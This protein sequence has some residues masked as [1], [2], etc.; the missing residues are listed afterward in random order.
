MKILIVTAEFGLNGGGLSLSCHK[1][2]ELLSS[3]DEVNVLNSTIRPIET[4]IGSKLHGVDD[5]IS[6]EY[7]LKTDSNDYQSTDIVIGFG[8]KFNGYYASLLAKKLKARFILSLRGSDVNLAKWSCENSWFLQEAVSTAETIV[9]LSKEMR[10][11]ILLHNH[12]AGP[13]TIIIPNIITKPISE[14]IR[15]VN[16]P[17]SVVIG[18]A[19]THLNEKKGITNL[20]SMIYE[21]KRISTTPIIL[22]LIGNIDDDLRKGYANHITKLDIKDNVRF[23]DQQT[24]S[25]LAKKMKDWDFYI[26]ASVCEGHPN[27][28]IEALQNGVPFISS[29]TGFLA[30]SLY[31]EIPELF[32]NDFRPSTMA[33]KLKSL[34]E[35]PNK[36]LLY[37]KAFNLLQNKCNNE[38]ILNLWKNVLRKSHPQNELD[39]EQIISVGLHDVEGVEHD[40]ITTPVDVFFRFVK[41]IYEMGYGLCSM[42]QYLEK[43]LEERKRWIVCTFDDGY[44]GL[45]TNALPILN[46]YGYTAT[47]FIC[48]NL[49]GKENRWNNKDGVLRR[50]LNLDDLNELNEHGWEIA[51]HGVNHYNLLKLSDEEI[52]YELGYSKGFIDEIWH[53]AETYAYP[54]G[55]FND[56]IKSYVGK[57]YQYAF[58]VSKG[59]TS[60]VTDKL[61][62]RRYSI[63]EIFKILSIIP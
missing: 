16:S 26:Q 22:E 8:G 9:C 25:D 49:I 2:Y 3:C 36:D 34:I 12:L 23:C 63:T 17:S 48:T 7:K 18:C 46:E 45:K 41:T 43:D 61:Q 59:G 47:V 4:T 21:F 6:L 33:L 39:I 31:N 60:L 20:L 54:Y 42:R 38:I 5:A 44:E 14:H 13:K 37:N 55:A 62:I 52:Q 27:S 50:H 32:F 40:S 10:E 30:E 58:A 56:F 57:Y 15:F 28:I 29:R 1:L 35:L 51:S 11:N 19:A 24:R 53:Y